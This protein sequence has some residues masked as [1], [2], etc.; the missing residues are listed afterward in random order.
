MVLTN[1]GALGR[2]KVAEIGGNL[3]PYFGGVIC[4]VAVVRVYQKQVWDCI[5]VSRTLKH[6]DI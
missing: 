6:G 1:G 2:V 3:T 5:F 4:M